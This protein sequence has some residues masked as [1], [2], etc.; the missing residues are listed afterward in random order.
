MILLRQLWSYNSKRRKRQF[1]FLLV[2]MVL[3]SLVESL[4]I[5]A[6]LPFLSALASPEILFNNHLIQPLINLLEL[7]KP[8]QILFPLTLFF[9]FA[10]LISGASRLLLLFVL[11]KFSFLTGA[12][13]SL[14]IY[15]RTLYQDYSVHLSRNS[16]EVVNGI[17]K[18]T[19]I[20]VS[21]IFVPFLTLISSIF[22]LIG[23]ISILFIVNFFI[24]MSLLSGFGIIYAGIILIRKKTIANNSLTI[25]KKS[26]H[27]IKVIKEG[28]GSIRDIILEAKQEFY[29]KLYLK[30]DYPFRRAEGSNQFIA[31]SPKFIIE[32][33]GISLI[34][35]VALY[36][37]GSQNS[38]SN[39][40]AVLGVLVMAC[41]RMLPIFQQAYASYTKIKGAQSSLEDIIELLN[42][43]LPNDLNAHR[44]NQK[45]TFEKDLKISNLSFS[46]NGKA[47]M[48]FKNL[49][50]VKIF[51]IAD[52]KNELKKRLVKRNQNSI[53]E[54]EKRFN[55][56]DDDIQ[57]WNDYDYIIINKNLDVCFRQIEEIILNNK[58]K[59]IIYPHTTQ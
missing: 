1:W 25:A 16:S 31:A 40:I 15:Q 46:H 11:T 33:L 57:H 44:N 35:L 53:E 41:Q 26:D 54:V 27:M 17:V 19:D 20:I 5:A 13:L 2:L 23:I 7:K 50:L 18:K 37:V 51:L 49:N 48:L 14:N 3:A 10:I 42:Q 28:L 45:F 38:S 8:D 9:I 39:Y 56:F 32:S 12:E 21:N 22:L 58:N 55:S 29:S 36:L 52:N 30:A 24:T 43:D 59:L 6:I 47:P 34:A 4:S